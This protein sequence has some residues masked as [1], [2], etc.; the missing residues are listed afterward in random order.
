M[1]LTI[2]P[3]PAPAQ[4]LDPNRIIDFHVNLE[5]FDQAVGG[6]VKEGGR[7]TITIKGRGTYALSALASDLAAGQVT[8]TLYRAS[9][10][11][12]GDY[13][14]VETVQAKVGVPIALK[15]I[16]LASVV[17]E[18][19]RRVRVSA[20]GAVPLLFTASSARPWSSVAPVRFFGE[21][22]VTCGNVR[23]CGCAVTHS[24]GSC[25]SDGCCEEV[26]AG[27]TAAADGLVPA[28][29][30]RIGQAGT[31]DCRKRVPDGERLFTRPEALGRVTLRGR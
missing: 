26:P 4:Q 20:S 25:C 27:G 10:E 5:E 6:S 12:S 7:Y 1:A 24:C 17:V 22:C 13:R 8:L 29:P 2:A 30:L 14:P 15:S 9:D 18:E 21:C 11:R 16:P 28:P 3:A 23:V 31:D 19:I